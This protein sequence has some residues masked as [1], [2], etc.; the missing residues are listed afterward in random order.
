MRAIFEPVLCSPLLNRTRPIEHLALDRLLCDALDGP[1]T[2]QQGR[3]RKIILATIGSLGDIH[4]F[5]AI[6]LALKARGFAVTVAVP[7]SLMEKVDRA[8]LE[9]VSIMPAFHEIW[10]GL[11]LS[12]AQIIQR[13]IDDQDFM[14]RRIAFPA[15]EQGVRAL[16]AISQDACAIVGSLFALAAPIVAE[17]LGIP[18]IPAYL[19]PM[20]VF[21]AYDPPVGQK[22]GTVSCQRAMPWRLK[23]NSACF[24]LIRLEMRRRYTAQ[25]NKV[26]V[27]NGLPRQFTTPILD[28][29]SDRILRLGLYPAFFAPPQP[30]F[31]H[32]F[33]HVGFPIFD[34]GNCASPTLDPEFEAFLDAGPAPLVFSLGSLVT[35]VAEDFYRESAAVARALG[36]RA[37][38]LTGGAP[39]QAADDIF[40]RPY[41]PHS[42]VFPRAAA[43]VHHGGIGTSAQALRAGKPQMIVPHMGD[44]LDNGA[45]IERLTVG[46]VVPPARFAARRVAPLLREMLADKALAERARALAA[47]VHGQNGA[48]GAALAIERALGLAPVETTL[49]M[50]LEEALA[51]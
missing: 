8:G 31:P 43:I 27:A 4:P 30:D 44:Q 49:A 45:R 5:I 34:A 40:V 42:L 17:K 47:E 10:Q 35:A 2:M 46:K 9:A 22:F 13:I 37:V 24:K 41:A 38:L 23:W 6:G 28:L 16:E 20:T 50:T 11:G 19:Q 18:Y 21:S 26:R 25:L 3:G 33:H 39:A 32:N 29:E 48:I 12:E 14:I 15:I 1:G 7:H 36:M 51:T